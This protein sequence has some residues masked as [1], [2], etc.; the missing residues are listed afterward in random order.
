MRFKPAYFFPV[1]ARLPASELQTET[2]IPPPLHQRVRR[3]MSYH[4]VIG[5]KCSCAIFQPPLC[6]TTTSV[7][8][9]LPWM[10]SP[11]ESKL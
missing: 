8:R 5:D 9:S 3:P 4:G 1:G 11:P 2:R 10:T 6:L 7:E